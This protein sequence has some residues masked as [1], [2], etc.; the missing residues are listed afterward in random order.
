MKVG[1]KEGSGHGCFAQ[2]GLFLWVHARGKGI[3]RDSDKER[4][5]SKLGVVFC[6]AVSLGIIIASSI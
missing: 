2:S 5:C 4:R 6:C 3:K 1:A